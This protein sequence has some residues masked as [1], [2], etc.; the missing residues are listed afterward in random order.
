[1]KRVAKRGLPVMALLAAGCARYNE[2]GSGA[3]VMG[4]IF[5]LIGIALGIGLIL[6]NR[7]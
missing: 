6:G 3:Y 2:Q 5:L 7:D 1:V 4:A